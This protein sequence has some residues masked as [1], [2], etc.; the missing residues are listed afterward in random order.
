MDPDLQRLPGFLSRLNAHG[1]P[2]LYS[3]GAK[4]GPELP[5]AQSERHTGTDM[6]L[7]LAQPRGP[8]SAEHRGSDPGQ[9][10]G[11]QAGRDV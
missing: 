3:P 10:P 11:T 1:G 4:E 9:E 7:P 8:P 2:A 5:G 6:E